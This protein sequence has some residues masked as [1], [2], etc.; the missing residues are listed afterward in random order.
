MRSALDWLLAEVMTRSWNHTYP[1][2][3]NKVALK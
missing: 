1:R 2:V 3:P